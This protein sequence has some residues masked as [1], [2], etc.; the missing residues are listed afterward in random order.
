MESRNII[1]RDREMAELQRCLDSDR[2][3]LFAFSESD[4]VAINRFWVKF[5]RWLV[6]GMLTMV[7]TPNLT[8]IRQPQDSSMS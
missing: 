7:L 3:E 8:I 4:Y 6:P 5:N 1:G 2:S